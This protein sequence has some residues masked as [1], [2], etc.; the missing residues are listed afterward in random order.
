MWNL[1]LLCFS[2]S[3]FFLCC[4]DRRRSSSIGMCWEWLVQCATTARNTNSAN[5]QNLVLKSACKLHINENFPYV[6]LQTMKTELFFAPISWKATPLL[7]KSGIWRSKLCNLRLEKL[8]ICGVDCIITRCHLIKICCL[9][10][11]IDSV[12]AGPSYGLRRDNKKV[13]AVRDHGHPG[14][15][16]G[17]NI[18]THSEQ[19]VQSCRQESPG[20]KV[21]IVSIFE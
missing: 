17:P 4:K 20:Q 1:T 6:T 12:G 16:Q 8:W 9:Q 18:S 15:C 3:C 2:F 7:I 5:L 21:F 19:L 11:T 10:W 14:N 13:G